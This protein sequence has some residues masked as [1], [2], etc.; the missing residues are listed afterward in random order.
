M[1]GVAREGPGTGNEFSGFIF[2][3][4]V[5][6]ERAAVPR[7]GQGWRGCREGL[8]RGSCG[9]VTEE[10]RRTEPEMFGKGRLLV[11]PGIQW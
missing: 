6:G 9:P 8:W 3:R 1:E 7:R 10:R 11:S 5:T 4:E 2:D